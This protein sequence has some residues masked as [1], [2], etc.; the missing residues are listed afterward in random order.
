MREIVYK[1]DFCKAILSND[2]IHKPHLSL[3]LKEDSGITEPAFREGTKKVEFWEFRTNYE[4]KFQFCDEKCFGNFIK[5]KNN[6]DD[7]FDLEDE[8]DEDE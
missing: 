2:R 6:E 8:E 3:H 4:G 1:C 5:I 7:D